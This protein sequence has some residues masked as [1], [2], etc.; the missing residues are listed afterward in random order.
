V[1]KG[2]CDLKKKEIRSFLISEAVTQQPTNVKT[3]I[4]TGGEGDA[5]P[6]LNVT[7]GGNES[8]KGEEKTE[9]GPLFLSSQRGGNGKKEEGS[10]AAG[11]SSN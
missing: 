3:S 2:K 4:R 1:L 10:C 8:A 11:E 5:S 6:L 9:G 7:T